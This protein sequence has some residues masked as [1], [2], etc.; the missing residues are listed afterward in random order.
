MFVENWV[1]SQSGNN[2][3]IIASRDTKENLLIIHP[4]SEWGID[5]V[6]WTEG[7]NILLQAAYEYYGKGK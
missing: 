3:L 6:W 5:W 2:H 1:I 4:L 7:N